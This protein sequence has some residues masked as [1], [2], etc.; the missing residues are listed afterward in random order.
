MKKIKLMFLV[1][2][3][4]GLFFCFSALPV[5]A[6]F[7]MII[8]S[9]T[10]VMPDDERTVHLTISFSHPFE[11]IG[12]NLA[13]PK[14]CTVMANGALQDLRSTM[15]PVQVMQHHAWQIDYAHRFGE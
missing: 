12:M 15:T 11:G 10:M 7:G 4:L 1:G 8:P 3:F 13:R 6:H 2:I 5:S 9:D 14:T